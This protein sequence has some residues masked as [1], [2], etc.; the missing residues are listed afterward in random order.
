MVVCGFFH[1]AHHTLDIDALTK[2]LSSI[3]A[4]A[5]HAEIW[6]KKSRLPRGQK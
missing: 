6:R 5:L 2:I 3:F 1:F 4:Q